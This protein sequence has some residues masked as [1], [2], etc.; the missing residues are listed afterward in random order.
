MGGALNGA[1]T[2]SMIGVIQSY[3]AGA[4][5]EGQAVNVLSVA[6]GVSKEK[7]RGLLSCE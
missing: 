1:Q 3:Q 2:Q 4:L 5:T 6:I 7:A